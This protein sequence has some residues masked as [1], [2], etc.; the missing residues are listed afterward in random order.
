VTLLDAIHAEIVD[1][2]GE[3]YRDVMVTGYAVVAQFVDRDGEQRMLTDSLE[4]QTA[5]ATLGLLVSGAITHGARF[6][7]QTGEP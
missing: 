2:F 7:R 5:S 4:G 1:A 6:A 3:D